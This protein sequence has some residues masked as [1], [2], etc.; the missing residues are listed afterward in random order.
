MV[1][2]D[3]RDML[4]SMGKD[5]RNYGLLELND[6]GRFHANDFLF[7]NNYSIFFLA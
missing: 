1:L 4:Q 7:F 2:T 6:A 3:I 5:I